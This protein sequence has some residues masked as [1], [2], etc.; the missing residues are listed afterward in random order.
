MCDDENNLFP[1]LTLCNGLGKALSSIYIYITS[2]FTML[3]KHAAIT[4]QITVLS[5]C[6]WLKIILQDRSK[7][8]ILPFPLSRHA[9]TFRGM[10]TDSSPWI[11]VTTNTV[12]N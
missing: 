9:T 12:L 3:L 4:C 1:T 11:T 8:M 5:Y 7:F 10:H 6:V 2:V